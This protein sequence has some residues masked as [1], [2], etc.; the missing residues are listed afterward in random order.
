MSYTQ[1]DNALW[2]IQLY[3]MTRYGVDESVRL[4]SPLRW[5]VDTGRASTAFLHGLV[6]AKPFVI[7]RLL[8]KGG[9]DQEIISRIRAKIE[10]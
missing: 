5:W 1:I 9:S 7:G 3:L 6:D 8:V 10:K 4:M 2:N